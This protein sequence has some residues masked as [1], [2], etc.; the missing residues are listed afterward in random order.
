MFELGDSI[1]Y[2]NYDSIV[3]PFM[4]NHCFCAY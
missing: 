4:V 2:A 1:V 3:L